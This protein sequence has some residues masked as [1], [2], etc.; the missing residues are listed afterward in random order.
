M[1]IG[2]WSMTGLI[3]YGVHA[4]GLSMLLLVSVAAAPLPQ[5]A[6]G[7]TEPRNSIRPLNAYSLRGESNFGALLAQEIERSSKMVNDEEVTNYLN[8]LA[9]KLTKNSSVPFPVQVKVVDSEVANEV[10]LP[11][12]FLYVNKGLILQ[13]EAELAGALAYGLA[14]TSI[15]SG[16]QIMTRSS[17]FQSSFP[18]GHVTWVFQWIGSEALDPLEVGA[19]FEL[20][21]LKRRFVVA[22][23]CLGLK[24][25]ESSGYDSDAII[26]FLGRLSP[27]SVSRSNKP[28]LFSAFPPLSQRLDSL[29]QAAARFPAPINDVVVSSSE[30]DRVKERLPS[31]GTLRSKEPPPTLYRSLNH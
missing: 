23:D 3:R 18:I 28:N 24:Y 19:P 20:L 15:R 26:R 6:E 22:A 29:R 10:V 9:A 21:F 16:T 31:L 7:C 12:G 14:H 11:G 13:A 8:R 17:L 2:G 5:A 27:K 30:F 1:G 25:L 4:C